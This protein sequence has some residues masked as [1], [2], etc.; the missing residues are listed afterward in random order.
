MEKLNPNDVATARPPGQGFIILANAI[1]EII[2]HLNGPAKLQPV[3]DGV[4]E[5][6]PKSPSTSVGRG[7][8]R[9]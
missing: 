4:N 2:D 8:R 6:E 9:R 1:N 7:P 5:E 3:D